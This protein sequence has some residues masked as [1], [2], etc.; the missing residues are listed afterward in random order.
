MEQWRDIEGYEGIY[1]VSSLGRV[2]R[3]RKRYDTID[4]TP[5]IARVLKPKVAGKGYQTACLCWHGKHDYRYLHR[6]VAHAFIPN[7][8]GLREVNHKSGDKTDNQVEN[9]EWVT[10]SQNHRHAA[11]YGLAYRGEA[12]GAAKLTAPQ[13]REARRL[14]KTGI[15]RK[16]LA[17]KYGV[18][19]GTMSDA[20]AGRTWG[21]LQ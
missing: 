10:P 16:A 7:P 3:I 6:L 17:Q 12:N 13:V 19:Y 8:D 4:P 21:W 20:I 5:E 9:L 2:R 11:T 1:Q 18:C 15:T 14:S